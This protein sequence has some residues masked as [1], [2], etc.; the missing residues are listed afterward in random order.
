MHGDAGGKVDA[1][2]L[3]DASGPQQHAGIADFLHIVLHDVP[4]LPG[5]QLIA[6]FCLREPGRVF[7]HRHIAALCGK[8]LAAFHKGGAVPDNALRHRTAGRQVTPP[9]QHQHVGGQ[10]QAD[11]RQVGGAFALQDRHAFGHLQGVSD[12][13][14]QRLVHIGDKRRHLATVG[15]ADGYHL[16]GQLGGIL[17]IFHECTVAHGHIQQNSIG[18]RRQLFAHD[19]GGDQRNTAHCG[20]HIPQGVHLFVRHRDS[21]A[22]ANDRNADRIHLP[23]KF[24]LRQR[25]AGAGHRLHLVDGAAGMAQSPAAHFGNSHTAGGH[26]GRNDQRG[27]VPHAAGGVFVHLDALDG[28]QIHHITGASHHIGEDRGFFV[29]HTAQVNGHHQRG[30]LVVR[31]R[32]VHISVHRKGDLLPVQ[33][34]AVPFFGDNIVHSHGLSLLSKHQSPAQRAGLVCKI[35]GSLY[36]RGCPRPWAPESSWK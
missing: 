18:T 22:L 30:H 31:H 17:Q 32:A 23:E 13:F 24:L 25:G 11:F 12:V 6:V 28:G 16:T 33:L 10:L 8:H 1:V 36:R 35:T 29:G 34:S 4:V 3:F 15:S 21:S 2:L 7:Q 20:G 14:A 26:D 5:G 19:G 27:L 9:R